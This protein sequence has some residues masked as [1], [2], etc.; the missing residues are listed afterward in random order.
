M[1]FEVLGGVEETVALLDGGLRF[2]AEAED[3][4]GACG[5]RAV[6]WAAVLWCRRRR[7]D[8]AVQVHAVVVRGARK[9]RTGG[10]LQANVRGERIRAAMACA[11]V[12]ILLRR[13][14]EQ[15]GGQ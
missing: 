7:R 5:L 15:G 9:S 14:Q 10:W 11:T 2:E 4:V 6:W 13:Q 3:G 12:V 1:G 8:G